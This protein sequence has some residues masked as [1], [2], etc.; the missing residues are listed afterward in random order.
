M[1]IYTDNSFVF[2][3]MNNFYK[4]TSDPLELYYIQP[5]IANLN[6]AI[7]TLY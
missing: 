2:K 4:I 6:H 7:S 1:K 5:L 3:L